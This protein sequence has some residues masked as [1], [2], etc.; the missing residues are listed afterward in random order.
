MDDSPNT[1]FSQVVNLV[2]RIT[3]PKSVS[4]AVTVLPIGMPVMVPKVELGDPTPP[5]EPGLV[6]HEE[7]LQLL[8]EVLAEID[9]GSWLAFD[10]L[11]EAFQ[12][13]PLAEGP[14]LR[15]LFR[16]Y[17]DLLPYERIKGE[18][19]CPTGPISSDCHGRICQLNAHK[20]T[21]N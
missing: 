8:N 13:F 18:V 21:Q 5:A 7:A 6:T 9:I 20:C 12:G 16:T 2:R 1:V 14:A 15:A 10:R 11:D 19:V 3:N 17:L 4:A